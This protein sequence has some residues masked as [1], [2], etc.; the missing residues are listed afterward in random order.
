VRVELVLPWEWTFFAK[1]AS[2]A[3]AARDH[4]PELPCWLVDGVA[5]TTQVRLP[6]EGIQAAWP[7][8]V[9][10]PE[11]SALLAAD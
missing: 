10:L 9:D 1:E 4:T 11:S 6:R 5:V 2:A 7:V 3:I 8:T